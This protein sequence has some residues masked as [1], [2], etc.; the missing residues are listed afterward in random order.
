VSRARLATAIAAGLVLAALPFAR[1]AHFGVPAAPHADHAPRHG[2]Q[3]G[4]VGDHH[5]ELRRWRGHVEVFVSDAWRQSVRPREGWVVFD[6]TNRV[7]L[8]WVGDRFAA[9]DDPVAHQADTVVILDDGTRLAVGFDVPPDRQ[10]P[11]GSRNR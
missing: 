3:L 5:V 10:T 7:D 1:Y 8:R 4:M 11:L 9:L 2:G 6:G